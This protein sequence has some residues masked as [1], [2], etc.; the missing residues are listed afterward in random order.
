[1]GPQKE[2]PVVELFANEGGAQSVGGRL[3]GGH[4]VHS[5]EGVIMLVETDAGAFQFLLDEGVA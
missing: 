5:K 4:V 3:Q 1:L 2:R